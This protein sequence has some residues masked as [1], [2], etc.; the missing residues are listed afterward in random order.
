MSGGATGPHTEARRPMGRRR[1]GL[2]LLT[3]VAIA[4]GGVAVTALT[5]PRTPAPDRADGKGLPPA[6]APVTRGTSPTARNRTAR[7]ATSANARSTRAAREAPSPGSPRPA[8]SC[9]ATS[10]STRSTARPYG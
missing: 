3:V 4:G 8:R 5:G 1:L 10:G 2:A 7:S 9:G 6:T